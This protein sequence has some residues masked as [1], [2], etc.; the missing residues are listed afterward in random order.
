MTSTQ[1][2]TGTKTFSTAGRTVAKNTIQPIPPGE[3]TL[4][5]RADDISVEQSDKKPDAVP[6]VKYSL[7][8]HGT[9]AT[10]GGK[11]RRVF[12]SLFLS[13]SPGKDGVINIDRASGLVALCKALGTDTEFEEAERTVQMPDGSEKVLKFL[14]PQQVADFLR[15][16]VGV[17]LKG[18]VK[19]EPN[20]YNGEKTER[21]VIGRFIARE[22]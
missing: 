4:S 7:E 22:A 8:A 18:Y 2:A 19:V 15:N 10:E 5:I 16:S 11:N 14:N 20:E 21:N 9:A 3:Y 6:Y 1:T 17:E 13:L 12:C